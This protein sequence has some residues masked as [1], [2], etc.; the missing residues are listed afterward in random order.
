MLRSH[1]T[2]LNA[3]RSQ[4]ARPF[5][6]FHQRVSIFWS[7]FC[8]LK[9]MSWST[10]QAIINKVFILEIPERVWESNGNKTR[11][12]EEAN[13][14][15]SDMPSTST[16]EIEIPRC[17]SACSSSSST[18]P[19]TTFSC[20]N[21]LPCATGPET[22]C[23]TARISSTLIATSCAASQLYDCRL[24]PS[25]GG[26]PT[27]SGWAKATTGVNTMGALEP[28]VACPSSMEQ[29]LVRCWCEQCSRMNM[30][31]LSMNSILHH[32]CE[33]LLLPYSCIV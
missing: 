19:N 2:N 31:K 25:Q 23:L 3:L 14:L 32:L 17:R 10:C 15:E 30:H 20:G 24:M 7:V 12:Q 33:L 16:S 22:R 21:A 5:L 8:R 6:V 4:E 9:S 27:F 18:E 28:P 26:P 29:S 11:H 13:S 1:Q